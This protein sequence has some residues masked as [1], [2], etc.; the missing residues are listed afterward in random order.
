MDLRQLRYFVAL[1]ETQNF[2][3]AAE[4]LNISQPPLTVAIRKL[5]QDLGTQL[6]E[7]SARG[8]SLTPAAAAALDIAKATLANAERFREAVREGAAGESG[9]LRVGFVGS[10]T[11][12][13]L[14]RLIPRFRQ[15]YPKVDLIL[16][17]STSVDI[18]RRLCIGEMDVGLLRLPL[19][20][21]AAV[22]AVVIDRDELHAAVP[23]H[24]PFASEKAVPL[25]ALARESFVLQSSISVLH[26]ITLMACH[27]AGFVPA[28]A[29]EATQLSAVLSLVRSG[30][31]VALVPARAGRSVPQGVRLLRLERRVPIE[32]GVALPRQGAGRLAA[33]FRA[34]AIEADSWHVSSTAKMILD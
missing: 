19:L 25:E 4:R 20:E 14:P 6:F 21:P 27:E 28:V 31:G 2:H 26:A 3:R 30:F 32:T 5:E 29:Q 18:A 7:R 17:E 22:E 33:N 16:E 8:V 12:E 15:R 10:A 13:L 34:L 11:F 23:E 1:A 9:K 24:S